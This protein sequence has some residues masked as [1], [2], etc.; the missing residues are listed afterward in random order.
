MP[1]D[2]GGPVL[3]TVTA[4]AIPESSATLQTARK[5]RADVVLRLY[6]RGSIDMAQRLAA[7]EIREVWMALGRGLF[8]QSRF[9]FQQPVV[10]RGRR[11]YRD[12]F[13]RLSDRQRRLYERRYRI[14]AA[15]VG[16]MK[17]GPVRT[18]AALV[19]EIVIENRGP[20]QLDRDWRLRNG[21][22]REHL[23]DALDLY[24]SLAMSTEKL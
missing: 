9:G 16:R 5:L 18:L 4:G 20:R 7:E 19:H 8:P 17:V 15:E 6:R 13:E 10:A 23:R 2:G 11:G 24:A 21:T 22:A 12:P 1:R 3:R 14:W